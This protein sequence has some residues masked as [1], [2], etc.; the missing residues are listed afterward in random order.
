M[1]KI[2]M[3][4]PDRQWAYKCVYCMCVSFKQL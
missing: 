2:E 1:K 4:L 3:Y